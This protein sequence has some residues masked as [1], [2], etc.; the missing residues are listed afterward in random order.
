MLEAKNDLTLPELALLWQELYH[1]NLNPSTFSRLLARA[2]WTQKKSL[3]ATERD[4]QARNEFKTNQAKL[5]ADK[6]VVLDEYGTNTALTP[7]HAWS[8]K[9]QRANGTAPRNRG[10]NVTLIAALTTSEALAA[11]TSMVIE[12]ATDQAAFETYI[13][14]VLCPHL[15]IG[16]TAIMD[17]LSAHKSL[18]VKKLIEAKG[19]K[20]LFLP[21]YS[22]DLSP[23]EMAFPSSRLT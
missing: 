22:P 21:A 2:G 4:K 3:A 18:K 12:G 20:E 1:Q 11:Q 7:T 13:E 14:K 8:A 5:E 10:K 9:G 6:V 15:I 23:I 19:C 16:Q 17:N